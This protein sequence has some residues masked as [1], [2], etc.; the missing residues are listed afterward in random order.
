MIEAPSHL[1]NAGGGR[2]RVLRLPLSVWCFALRYT[3]EPGESYCHIC[4]CTD[5]YGCAGGCSW[6]DL[7]HTV[8]SR[9]FRKEMLP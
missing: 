8:C 1:I 3:V 2:I 4:G 6:V 9:C 7:A 5:T